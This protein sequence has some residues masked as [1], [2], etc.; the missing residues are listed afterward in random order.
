MV[1]TDRDMPGLTEWDV[2]R[3]AKATDP[4][5]PV[6]LVTGGAGSAAPDGPAMGQRETQFHLAVH[7]PG[8]PVGLAAATGQPHR[9]LRRSLAPSG[10]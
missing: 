2:A 10:R 7:T 1:V 9:R 8:A 6:V 3:L 5:V 4:H